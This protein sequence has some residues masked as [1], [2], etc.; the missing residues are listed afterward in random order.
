M[1]NQI[2]CLC[3]SITTCL[4]AKA[5]ITNYSVFGGETV[6][7]NGGLACV[8]GSFENEIN[9]ADGD[10]DNYASYTSL[11]D[12]LGC[13]A[14]INVPL[15][16]DVTTM[17][18]ATSP[19]AQ[20]FAGFRIGISDLLTVATNATINTYN[21]GVL[22]E[23]A[24]GSTLLTLL[25]GGESYLY[26]YA[27]QPF[28]QVELNITSLAGALTTIDYYYGIATA[29][30]FSLADGPLSIATEEFSGKSAGNTTQLE[31]QLSKDHNAR[32][33]YVEK[34]INSRTFNTIGSVKGEHGVSSYT[35]ADMSPTAGV[36]NYY[37][38]R[39]VDIAGKESYSK[40]VSIRTNN[41]TTSLTIYP[42]PA[43]D[44]I[45]INTPYEGK[46]NIKII[47]LQGRIVWEKN[48]DNASG[49]LNADDGLGQ[50]GRGTY[51]IQV[52]NNSGSF[53]NTQV[54]FQ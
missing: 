42:N 41:T 17:T 18:I 20:R 9:V 36:T 37:R 1:K 8:G 48:Y 43:K 31:W 26:M 39:M 13:S 25:L 53:I 4:S 21:N 6:S 45:T 10:L 33:F 44:Q 32:L 22:V 19:T 35:F 14:T 29:D 34:S 12:L 7:L 2:L 3:I 47:D 28:N 51:L 50:I 54:I 27:T 15:V 52:H 24:S 23:T 40:I 30:T 46:Q 38:L 11:V 5:Q 49:I 16:S